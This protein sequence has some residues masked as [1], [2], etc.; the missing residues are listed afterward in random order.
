[1]K[2]FGDR[3]V[4]GAFL[5]G[6][7]VAVVVGGIS[8]FAGLDHQRLIASANPTASLESTD[9]REPQCGRNAVRIGRR[10]HDRIFI[11][12]AFSSSVHRDIPIGPQFCGDGP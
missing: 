7:A 3:R 11:A 2:D 8:Y 1:M 4:R 9:L 6:L 12:L 5:V 10:L